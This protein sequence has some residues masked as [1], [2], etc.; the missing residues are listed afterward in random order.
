MNTNDSCP[1][2]LAA[3]HGSPTDAEILDWLQT[4][5][6]HDWRFGNEI[7]FTARCLSPLPFKDRPTLREAVSAVIKSGN[8]D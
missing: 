2:S 8:S 7:Y 1:A 5:C 4:N 3:A 6:R